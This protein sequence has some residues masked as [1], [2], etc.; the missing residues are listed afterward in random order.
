MI[1]SQL[2]DRFNQIV[3]FATK[4]RPRNLTNIKTVVTDGAIHKVIDEDY[5]EDSDLVV[6]GIH[7]RRYIKDLFVGSLTRKLIEYGH[8]PLLLT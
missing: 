8:T 2:G 4:A 6:A 3:K 7:S 1:G 5:I